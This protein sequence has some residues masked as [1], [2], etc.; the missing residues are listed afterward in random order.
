MSLAGRCVLVV[1]DDWFLAETI[2]QELAE[3]GAEVLGPAPSV[4]DALALLDQHG[5]PDAAVLD[6]ELSDGLSFPVAEALRAEQVP[7]VFATGRAFHE[8]QKVY[9][10]VPC[11]E[12]PLALQVLRQLLA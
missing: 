12:K 10:D 5:V 11:V 3:S 4:N 9:P 1:E 6:V 8:V 7:V 2:C